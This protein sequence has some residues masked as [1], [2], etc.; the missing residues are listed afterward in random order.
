MDTQMTFELSVIN[1]MALKTGE[2]ISLTM[3]GFQSVVTSAGGRAVSSARVTPPLLSVTWE[4]LSTTDPS[5]RF[6]F[7]ATEAVP[8]DTT[9]T[10]IIVPECMFTDSDKRCTTDEGLSFPSGNQFVP[11]S[12]MLSSDASN[13]IVLPIPVRLVASLTRNLELGLLQVG[14]AHHKP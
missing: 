4:R 8:V 9:I 6:H 13:G 12:L 7:I 2:R 3:P 5:P 1:K 14:R 11:S 10:I